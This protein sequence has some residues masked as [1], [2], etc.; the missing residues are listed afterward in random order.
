M[1]HRR[2]AISCVLTTL[3]VILLAASAAPATAQNTSDGCTFPV[4]ATDATGTNITVTERPTRI[5]ALQASAAQTLWELNTSDR[6][7]GAPH[8]YTEYLDEINN[9]TNIYSVEDF[10]VDQ[11]LVVDLDADLILAPNAIPDDTV[12]QLRDADQTVYKFRFAATLEDIITK[13]T[14]TGELVGACD[15]ATETNDD[16]STRLDAVRNQTDDFDSPRV[17]H[18]MDQ[19]GWTAGEGTFIHDLITTAGGRNIAAVAGVEGYQQ[20]SDEVVVEQNPNVITVPSDSPGIPESA[21]YQSTFAVEN[22]Q[23]VELNGNYLSQPA[24]R[25]I[26][27][28]E[29]MA[30]AFAAADLQSPETPTDQPDDE[31]SADGQT[32]TETAPADD[33]TIPGF[34]A[35][36]AVIAL[37]TGAL[38]AGRIYR[39]E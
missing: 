2:L 39:L 35:G 20:L 24:P 31:T 26:I 3:L 8:A 22:D 12:T 29:A 17:L 15:E 21:A 4:T 14:R 18:V 6:V 37:L 5:V 32:P 27:V 19:E 10:A 28:V 11:E 33:E 9:T 16:F 23:V 30:D 25:V 34:T 7:V 1:P 38:I 36:I 13:T